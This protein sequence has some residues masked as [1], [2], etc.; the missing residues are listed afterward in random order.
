GIADHRDHEPV[1]GVGGITEEYILLVD[2][3]LAA[4]VQ[5]SVHLRELPERGDTGTNDESQD[6]EAY[7]ALFRCTFQFLAL[8][9]EFSDVRDIVLGHMRQ[10]DPAC[11]EPRSGY[12][13]DAGQRL[14][15]DLAELREV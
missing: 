1:L 9:L 4:L 3:L 12:L 11:L 2:E 8:F 7:A 13:L 10:V 6:G 15:L 14:P 5:R